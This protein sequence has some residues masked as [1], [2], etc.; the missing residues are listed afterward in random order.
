MIVYIVTK[1]RFQLSLMWQWWCLYWLDLLNKSLHTCCSRL[2][3]LQIYT[4]RRIHCYQI[5]RISENTYT[6]AH[7]YIRFSRCMLLPRT[8]QSYIPCCTHY[9]QCRTLRLHL[10]ARQSSSSG[11]ACPCLCSACSLIQLAYTFLW[12]DTLFYHLI[13][14]NRNRKKARTACWLR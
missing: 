7:I 9:F 2:C 8:Y 14:C 5:S 1:F 13:F 3:T 10:L 12:I 6:I 4:T 11:I